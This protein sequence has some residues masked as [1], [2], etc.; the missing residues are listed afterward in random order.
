MENCR[1][2]EFMNPQISVIVPVYNSESTL[3]RCVDSILSQNFKNFELL[4]IDDGSTD[5]SGEI[6]DEY[7]KKDFR[8]KVFHKEN[9][10]VSS[11]RN[12]GLDNAKGEWITFV[13]SDDYIYNVVFNMVQSYTTDLLIFNH[14]IESDNNLIDAPRIEQYNVKQMLEK[15]LH[16]DVFRTPWA[17]FFRRDKIAELHFDTEISIGEDTLFVLQYLRSCS[18]ITYCNVDYYVWKRLEISLKIKYRL[19]VADA[20]AVVF[21]LY[22]SYKDLE[23]KSVDF[24][25]FIYEFYLWL[26][27]EDIMNNLRL[28]YGNRT[29]S[30]L[31]QNIKSA[32]YLK[33]RIIFMIKK[34]C[35]TIYVNIRRILNFSVL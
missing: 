32:Y 15:Y 24:E 10:G 9:G 31:W 11:A 2:N 35:P 12:V 1:M 20:I 22:D 26:C 7:A 28:W 16:Y 19:R 34:Y 23:I 21:K 3:N 27:S 29:I 25:R 14:K 5:C 6:C 17:K 8:V 30:V 4:L 33:A 18:S 13:D